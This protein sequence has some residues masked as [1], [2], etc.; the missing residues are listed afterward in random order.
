MAALSARYLQD[1][2]NRRAAEATALLQLG[3]FSGAYYLAGYALECGLKALIASR[4]QAGVIPDKKL[5]QQIHTH[6]LNEL[7][8]LAGIEGE[9]KELADRE[10]V[11][12]ANWRIALDWSEDSRYEIHDEKTAKDL[13]KATCDSDNGVFQW[14]R[15]KW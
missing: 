2:A 14:V 5:V 7:L 8:K 13:I 12:D 10:P 9:R 6:K 4:F 11:F 3:H 1:L 15:S